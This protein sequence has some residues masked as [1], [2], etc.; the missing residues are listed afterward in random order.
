M[1]HVGGDEVNDDA[2]RL[3]A[4]CRRTSDAENLK[5]EFIG[6]VIQWAA[7]LGISVQVWDDALAGRDERPRDAGQR[8]D[9][10][11][12]I[13]VNAWNIN[14]ASN[15]FTYADAD[16]KVSLEAMV[17]TIVTI[18]VCGLPVEGS[19]SGRLSK[20]VGNLGNSLSKETF[21]INFLR[22]CDQ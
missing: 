2:F 17:G 16:Y 15:A 22:K 4:A 18:V 5:Q 1:I 19:R 7:G 3:S 10:R 6:S 11:R 21:L 8:T 9:G 13:F 20:L 12:S 14:R